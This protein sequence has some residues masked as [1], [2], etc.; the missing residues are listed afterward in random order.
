VIDQPFEEYMKKHPGLEWDTSSMYR[1][2]FAHL[3]LNFENGLT[4]KFLLR[5]ILE[6]MKEKK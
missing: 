4:L 6:L 5:P 2:E 3:K 1:D